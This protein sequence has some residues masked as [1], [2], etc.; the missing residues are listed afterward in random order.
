MADFDLVGRESLLRAAA[1]VKEVGDRGLRIALQRNLRLAT[2]PLLPEIKQSALDTLPKRGGLAARVAGAKL[3]TSISLG[4]TV[5]VSIK[6]RGV[7]GSM[8][9][10]AMNEGKLRHPVFG[11]RAVWRTQTIRPHWFDLPVERGIPAIRGSVKLACDEI[12]GQ[13]K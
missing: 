13:F 11:N 12:A 3:S 9:V 10:K 5:R 2:A 8:D 7:E 6:A 4:K 1:H